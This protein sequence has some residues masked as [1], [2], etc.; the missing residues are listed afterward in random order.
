MEE[1]YRWNRSVP[2]ERAMGF[3]N[4]FLSSDVAESR[5]VRVSEIVEGGNEER[6]EIRVSIAAMG[7]VMRGSVERMLR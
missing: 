5:R 4:D 3:E 7:L 6:R 1:R 2:A